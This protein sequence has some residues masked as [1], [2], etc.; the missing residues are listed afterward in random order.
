MDGRTWS[1]WSRGSGCTADVWHSDFVIIMISPFAR[2][3]SGSRSIYSFSPTKTCHTKTVVRHLSLSCTF[4][5]GYPPRHVTLLLECSVPIIQ[6]SDISLILLP[7]PLLPS[8]LAQI[9][10]SS[11]LGLL[12]NC[13][14][15]C[16]IDTFHCPPS[17]AL[18]SFPGLPPL[19]AARCANWPK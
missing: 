16:S 2:C 10:F 8:V 7:H 17:S 1:S 14:S 4:H 19:S 15:I 12:L 18:R 11:W 3:T 13:K 5:L 6:I 9:L